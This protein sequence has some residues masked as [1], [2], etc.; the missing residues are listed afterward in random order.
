MATMNISLPAS[1]KAFVDEQVEGRGYG[2]SSE[3][4]RELIRRDQDR[5]KLRG[6]LLEGV[7]SEPREAADASYFA[8]LRAR[9]TG[10]AEG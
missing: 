9:V 10:R 6:L 5:Q 3:Y 7:G 4:V 2:T 8:K 1:L